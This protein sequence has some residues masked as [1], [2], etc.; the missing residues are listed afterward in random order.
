MNYPCLHIFVVVVVGATLISIKH[1]ALMLS[2][3]DTSSIAEVLDSIDDICLRHRNIGL[4][5]AKHWQ[6]G[7]HEF[8]FNE[9]IEIALDTSRLQTSNDNNESLRW[10]N[11][12]FPLQAPVKDIMQKMGYTSPVDFCIYRIWYDSQHRR[13]VYNE[14]ENDNCLEIA[15]SMHWRLKRMMNIYQA[16]IDRNREVLT[17]GT[18]FEFF[19]DVTDATRTSPGLFKALARPVLAMN[20]AG[21]MGDR[22]TLPIPDIYQLIGL[23]ALHNWTQLDTMI[24]FELSLP[25]KYDFSSYVT[26]WRYKRPEVVYRGMLYPTFNTD[27]VGIY[28]PRIEVCNSYCLNES[29]RRDGIDIGFS[30]AMTSMWG[31]C[32]LCS[33]SQALPFYEMAQKSRYQLNIDGIGAPY[34]GSLWKMASNSTVFYVLS[35]PEMQNAS[36]NYFDTYKSFPPLPILWQSWYSMFVKPNKHYIAIPPDYIEQA[37]AYCDEHIEECESIARL[38]HETIVRVVKP[39]VVETYVMATL[40]HLQQWQ[41]HLHTISGQGSARHKAT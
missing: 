29:Q 36:R 28:R 19:V 32:P 31:R 40:K 17:P 10:N 39:E 25:P 34:D 33:P 2:T 8:L 11:N 20:R 21:S 37:M 5:A 23:N 41:H 13:L 4:E 30:D 7:I 3:N 26:P 15:A 9:L 38:A 1:S 24:E 18:D 35:V 22:Y 27:R 14:T 12:G 16:L 6:R